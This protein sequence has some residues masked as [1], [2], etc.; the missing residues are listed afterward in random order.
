MAKAG[1][2]F[3]NSLVRALN[4]DDNVIECAYVES[5]IIPECKWFSTPLKLGINGIEKNYG[6]GQ[7]D[8]FEKKHSYSS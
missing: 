6:L 5:D 2:K 8:E 7:L 4:G 1:A 3:I